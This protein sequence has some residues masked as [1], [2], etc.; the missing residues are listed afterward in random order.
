[1]S[2]LARLA[3]EAGRTPIPVTIFAL[4]ISNERLV[5]EY[6]AAGASRF[7]FGLPAAGADTVLPIL[8]RYADLARG[9][10]TAEAV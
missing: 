9:F 10:T 1:M 4:G 8:D 3:D 6:Q 2:D 5:A 7:V